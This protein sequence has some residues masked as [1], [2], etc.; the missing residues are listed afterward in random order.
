[1]TD[2]SSHAYTRDMY[3][4]HTA[5]RRE[6]DALPNLVRNSQVPSLNVIQE[7]PGELPPEVRSALQGLLRGALREQGPRAFSSHS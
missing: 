3:M 5:F 7:T 1:M 4:V 6:F 2:T